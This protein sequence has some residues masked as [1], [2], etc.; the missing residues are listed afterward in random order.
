MSRLRER[1]GIVDANPER[2]NPSLTGDYP[3]AKARFL[4]NRQILEAAEKRWADE[5]VA[6][7]IEP[8]PIKIW[9]R[10]VPPSN[11]ASVDL[12]RLWTG[13]FK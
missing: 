12:R 1:E 7:A 9:E 10:A 6:M 3:K 5:Q 13:L 2:L 8:E 11:R 4:A